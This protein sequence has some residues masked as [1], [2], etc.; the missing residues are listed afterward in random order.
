MELVRT[1]PPYF[2]VPSTTPPP[3]PLL[4]LRSSRLYDYNRKYERRRVRYAWSHAHYFISLFASCLI[5]KII[6]CVVQ[7]LLALVQLQPPNQPADPSKYEQTNIAWVYLFVWNEV[8]PSYILISLL[9]YMFTF[10]DRHNYYFRARGFYYVSVFKYYLIHV[11]LSQ[12]F[13]HEINCTHFASP[14]W[15]LTLL[16][17]W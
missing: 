4:H 2:A 15:C 13:A 14:Q 9:Q 6:S 12:I 17:I 16:I 10:Y 7:L 1:L 5:I 11:T 8:T 3:P